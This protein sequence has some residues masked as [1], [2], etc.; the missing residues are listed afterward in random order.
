M[1]VY[2]KRWSQS[3]RIDVIPYSE[4]H[5]EHKAGHVAEV[6]VSDKYIQGT[7]NQ[8]NANG[9]SMF[10]TT[11][12]PTDIASDLDKYHVEFGGEVPST[13]VSDVLSWVLPTAIF[14]GVWFFVFR[15]F[16]EKQGFGGG[17]LMSIGRSKAKIYVETDT[18]T[19]FEDVA[20]VDEAKEELKEVIGFLKDPQRYGR[21]GGRVATGILLLG[22]PRTGRRSWIPRACARAASTGR[23]WSTGPTR[24]AACRSSMCI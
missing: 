21:L 1:L 19:T 23:S 9:K 10:V 3:Q 8:P 12:V 20:G 17:G 14:F 15:R 22:P 11:R 13:F 16:A 4:F 6:R 2:Q 7:L 18:K 24:W 5:Q